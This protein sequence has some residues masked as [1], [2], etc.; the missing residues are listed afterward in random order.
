MLA[1]ALLSIILSVLALGA[2]PPRQTVDE[3][4]ELESKWDGEGGWGPICGEASCLWG[5]FGDFA[6]VKGMN[7]RDGNGIVISREGC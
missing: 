5:P 4:Q 7:E 3:Q 2:A 6:N 1:F